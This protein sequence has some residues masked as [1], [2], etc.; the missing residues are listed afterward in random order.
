MRR[1]V[2]SALTAGVFAASVAVSGCGGGGIDE[3]MP[4]GDLKPAPVPENVQIKMGPPP[5][6]LP[7]P[8]KTGARI[9][10]LKTIV[11]V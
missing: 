2:M 8:G 10:P 4:Q 9:S 6:Q 11:Q 5:K 7:T 1:T 3:G